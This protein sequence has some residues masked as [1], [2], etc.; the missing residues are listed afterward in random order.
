[1][2]LQSE[3]WH[4]LD[5]LIDEP[6]NVEMPSQSNVKSIMAY[7]EVEESRIFKSTHVSQLNGSLTLSKDW[8]IR[9]KASLL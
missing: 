7:V 9:M 4:V 5:V 8:L 3:L 6:E 1:M 2:E